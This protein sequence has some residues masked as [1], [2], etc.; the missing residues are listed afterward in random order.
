[1]RP[2]CTTA[3]ENVVQGAQ[4]GATSWH[5]HSR[6]TSI[7]RGKLV[8]LGLEQVRLPDGLSF[9]LEIVRHP[10]GA[11]ALAVDH[12]AR[13]CLVRQ[14]RHAVG[15]WIWEI[16]AGKLDPG[17]QPEQTARRELEEE[18]GI[19]ADA[20]TSL[21]TAFS[22]PGF[23]DEELHL[24]LAR[25]LTLVPNQLEAHELLEVHWVD[26]SRCL[27]WAYADEIRDAKTL[28]AIFRAAP[29]LGPR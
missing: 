25:Q 18:A 24:F 29:L 17:E 6:R 12:Q 27:E 9:E 16:P 7:Y 8:N 28:I 14:Y 3:Q 13:V 10:G 26:F 21:G 19:R 4:M 23:C 2:S 5:L 20:W 22:T 1:M 15:G 11:G